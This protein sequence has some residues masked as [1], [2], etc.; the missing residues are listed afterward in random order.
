[1]SRPEETQRYKG[2]LEIICI[3]RGKSV[4]AVFMASFGNARK[5]KVSWVTS[6]KWLNELVSIPAGAET[7]FLRHHVQTSS[8]IK[9]AH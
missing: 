1:M 7:L 8:G 5:L 4:L 2:H 9:P 3:F 6:I